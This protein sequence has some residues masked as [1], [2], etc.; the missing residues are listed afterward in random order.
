MKLERFLKENYSSKIQIKMSFEVFFGKIWEMRQVFL[1]T[2]L[3]PPYS[4]IKSAELGDYEIK[5]ILKPYKLP[6]E[7]DTEGRSNDHQL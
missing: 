4:F 6:T 2:S 1:G 7:R 3:T 5:D